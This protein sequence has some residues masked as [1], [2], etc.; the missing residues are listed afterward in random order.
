MGYFNVTL[1]LLRESRDP[2]IFLPDFHEKLKLIG[3]TPE[4]NKYEYLVFNDSR[5]DDEK[6]PIE[7]Y[8]TMTEATVLDMLCSWKGLG[9]LSYRHPDFSFPF[10]INYLSWD[11]V[12]LGGFDIGFYNKEFYNQDAGTKHEKLIRE[13]GTIADYKYIVGDIGMASDNCIESHLTLAETE[14]FIESHTFEINIRR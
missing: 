3:V 4:I 8:E 9:L 10:S 1:V 14:A 13:I 7:L 12:T 5:D 2:K 11:D 6:D